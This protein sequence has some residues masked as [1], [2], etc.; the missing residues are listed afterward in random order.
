I[1]EGIRRAS[2]RESL[3]NPTPI[4]PGKI[5]EYTVSLWETSMVFKAGHGIRLEV[6]SSNFPRYARN[7]NTGLPLGTSDEMKKATQTVSHDAHH[8]SHLVLPIIPHHNGE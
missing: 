2:F 3:E 5:Y 8:A 4:D 1:C 7:L 6:S